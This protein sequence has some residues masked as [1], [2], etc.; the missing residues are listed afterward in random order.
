MVLRNKVKSKILWKVWRKFLGNRIKVLD[1][2]GD[3]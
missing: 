2:I 3:F 1:M